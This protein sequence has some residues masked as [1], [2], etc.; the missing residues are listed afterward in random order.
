MTMWAYAHA[1]R[2]YFMN[3]KKIFRIAFLLSIVLFFLSCH[4][5]AKD[6]RKDDG[7]DK[8][9][10]QVHITTVENATVSVSPNIKDGDM[11]EEGTVF[12]VTVTP[13]EPLI[14]GAGEWNIEGNTILEGGKKGDDTV[15]IK[16]DSDIKISHTLKVVATA[17]HIIYDESKFNHPA[18]LENGEDVMSGTEVPF[19]SIISFSAKPDKDK[20][21]KNWLIN[22][23]DVEETQYL[24]EFKL[25]AAIKDAKIQDGR[26]QTSID[27]AEKIPATFTLNFDQ[28]KMLSGTL[29]DQLDPNASVKEGTKVVFWALVDVG[30]AV[31]AWKNNGVELANSEK[32]IFFHYMDSDMNV[33]FEA[34]DALKAKMIYDPQ[35]IWCSSSHPNPPGATM[36]PVSKENTLY[37]GDFLS[38]S[39]KGEKC[40]YSINGIEPEGDDIVPPGN[41][42]FLQKK[43]FNSE[44]ELK[45]EIIE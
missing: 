9:K 18:K 21:V 35:K 40:R 10:Y 19:N 27:F 42:I 14:Y 12:T 31:K 30:K 8:K 33:T 38:I 1:S 41:I 45:L 29:T 36:L 6:N 37:E 32:V 26:L 23:S 4:N 2:S 13:T 15:K 44:G 34:K 11:I 16:L 3:V 5:S 39:K 22:G 20:I 43:Y 7:K 24:T 17:T 28:S 25:E